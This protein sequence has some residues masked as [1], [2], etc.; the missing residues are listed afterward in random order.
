[1]VKRNPQIIVYQRIPRMMKEEEE[2]GKELKKKKK[3]EGEKN[4]KE[5]QHPHIF[6]TEETLR[7]IK[8]PKSSKRTNNLKRKAARTKVF[9]IIATYKVKG[10]M[11]YHWTEKNNG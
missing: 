8:C 10:R 6:E 7:K 11:R 3:K 1:M 9:F 2:E 5:G 4:K